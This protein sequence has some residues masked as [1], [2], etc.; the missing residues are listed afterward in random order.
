VK[1]EIQVIRVN[2]RTASKMLGTSVRQLRKLVEADVFTDNRNGGKATTGA[3]I[4]LLTDE[5]EVYAQ[6]GVE[7]LQQ[8]R[9]EKGRIK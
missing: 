2:L 6:K 7:A 5:V 4:Y 8:Y 9:R 3:R 1:Q